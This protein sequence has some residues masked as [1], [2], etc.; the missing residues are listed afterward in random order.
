MGMK[1]TKRGYKR[2]RYWGS[3]FN[4]KTILDRT[5]VKMTQMEMVMEMNR[6]TRTDIL[7]RSFLVVV[8][9]P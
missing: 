9:H 8:N 6:R 7:K 1:R 4:S 2:N 3:S 5:M